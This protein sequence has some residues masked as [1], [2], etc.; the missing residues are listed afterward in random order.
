MVK[1]KKLTSLLQ[2]ATVALLEMF[3]DT[4]SHMY[5]YNGNSKKPLVNNNSSAGAN[6]NSHSTIKANEMYSAIYSD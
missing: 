1:Q 3:T 6:I 2:E 5:L 4:I